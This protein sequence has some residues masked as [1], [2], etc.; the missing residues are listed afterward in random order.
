MRT[1]L[2]A[3]YDEPNER[4][5]YGIQVHIN[6]SWTNLAQNGRSLLYLTRA[7]SETKRKEVRGWKYDPAT[8]KPINV[9]TLASWPK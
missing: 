6:G 3:W 1:K 9:K 8:M 4:A 7:E 5:L 2:T